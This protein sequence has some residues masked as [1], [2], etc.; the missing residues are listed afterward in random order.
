[1]ETLGGDLDDP[2]EN[3][4]SQ[5]HHKE[6]KHHEKLLGEDE[7]DLNPY[8]DDFEKSGLYGNETHPA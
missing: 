5:L 4:L 8:G 1:M 2:I 7:G 3:R 6:K